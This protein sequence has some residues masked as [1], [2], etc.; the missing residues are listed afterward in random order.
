M[1]NELDTQQSITEE[2]ARNLDHANRRLASVLTEI[3]ERLTELGERQTLQDLEDSQN[4]WHEHVTVSMRLGAWS[5]REGS[6]SQTLTYGVGARAAMSRIDE[7]QSI[8]G[9]LLHGNPRKQ[10]N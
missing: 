2:A 4:A 1:A 10:N 9:D 7:L 3:R 8:F 6:M 5:A